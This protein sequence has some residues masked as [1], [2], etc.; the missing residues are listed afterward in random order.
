M[1]TYLT[2]YFGTVLVS[3]LLVPFISRLAKRYHFVDNPGPRKVH[4]MP[5]PRVGGIVFILS[6]FVFIIPI[7]FLDNNI[8]RSFRQSSIEFV[9]LLAGACFIFLVGL[10]DDFRSVRGYIKLLCLVIASIAICSSGATLNSFSLGSWELNT[11]WAAWPLT[12][13]WIIVV[14]V[15]ISMIDGLDGLAAG[16]AAIVCGTIVCLALWSGQQAMAILMLAL[17]GS[18][19]GFLF[20]NFYPAKIFMGDCGSMFLGFMIGAGSIVCQTKMP[21]LLGLSIPFLVLGAPIF[22]MG[23]VIVARQILERRSMFAPTRTT[24]IINC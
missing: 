12:I 11:G 15:C 21:T 13:I 2:I 3:M 1:K 20:F 24:C 14:T 16:I 23:L 5:V 4:K 18:V 9:T 19:T 10:I 7:F 8:G 6:T 22:D 17:L